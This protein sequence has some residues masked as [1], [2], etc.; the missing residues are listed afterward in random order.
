MSH[1]FMS[2]IYSVTPVHC[3]T[4]A[5]SDSVDLPIA[6]ESHTKLPILPAS[7]LKGA[8]RAHLEMH[9]NGGDAAESNSLL[10]RA[11]GPTLAD[12]GK[13]EGDDSGKSKGLEVGQLSF[14]DGQLLAFPVRSLGRPFM[15][16]TSPLLLE[17]FRRSFHVFDAAVQWP[18]EVRIPSFQASGRD[19]SAVRAHVVAGALGEAKHLVLEDLIYREDEVSAVE[20]L[21][22]LLA[23]IEKLLPEASASSDAKPGKASASSGALSGVARA[24]REGFVVISDADLVDLVERTVPVQARVKLNEQKTTGSADD[25]SGNLW[26]EE[27]LP[28]DC[29]FFAPIVARTPKAAKDGVLKQFIDAIAPTRHRFQ[30]GGNETVGQG[31]CLVGGAAYGGESK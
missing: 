6:R 28:A 10:Y 13:A 1:L 21:E 18:A 2:G 4:G 19:Q 5:A 29:L 25:A 7:S 15:Y 31:R 16:V 22:P 20:N 12:S 3:G 17:R 24:L 30:I 14:L 23:I 8:W 11:F 9:G 26:Y 27:V